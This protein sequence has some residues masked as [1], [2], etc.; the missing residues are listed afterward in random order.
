MAHKKL[1]CWGGLFVDCF[2]SGPA[3][4]KKAQGSLQ[5]QF[6][7]SICHAFFINLHNAHIR[8]CAL[9]FE[10]WSGKCAPSERSRKLKK[11]G[12]SF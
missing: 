9:S 10:G 6:L 7:H 12:S 2:P 5:S 4:V 3:L 8:V 11:S 1:F